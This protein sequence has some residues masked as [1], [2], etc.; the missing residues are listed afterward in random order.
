M[1]LI[2]PESY[3]VRTLSLPP[4]FDIGTLS[5]KFVLVTLAVPTA[6]LRKEIIFIVKLKEMEGQGSR[7][8]HISKN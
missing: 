3:T 5:P 4:Y 8:L 6:H 2:Y 7:D 1:T